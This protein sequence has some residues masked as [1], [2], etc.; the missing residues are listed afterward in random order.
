METTSNTTELHIAFMWNCDHC[1][2]EQFER[3]TRKSNVEIIKQDGEYMSEETK[4]F[5]ENIP[6]IDPPSQVHCHNCGYEYIA[7]L[8]F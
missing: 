4:E 7:V 2:N 5:L 1:G 3:G 6:H 8:P